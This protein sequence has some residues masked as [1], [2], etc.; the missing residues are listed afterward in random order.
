MLFVKPLAEYEIITLKSM[1]NNHPRHMSRLRAAVILASNKGCPV[2][3]I[4]Y[5][6]DVCRQSVAGW[7][8]LWENNGIASLFDKPRSGR[9][10]KLSE[11]I[12]EE[13][14]KLVKEEPRSIKKVL[15]KLRTLFGIKNISISTVKRIC[16]RAGLTWKRIR[17]SLKNKRNKDEFEKT[18]KML[19]ELIEKELKGDIDLYYFDE[20]GFNLEPYVPYA[21]QPVN[22][23]IEV[24]SSKSNRLNVLG[25]INKNCDFESFVFE[26]GVNSSI[27]IACFDAFSKIITKNTYILVDNASMHTSNEFKEQIEKWRKKGLFVVFNAPYS[28]E[29]NIIEILWR[30]IKYEWMPFSA[31]DSYENLKDELFKILR[32]IGYKNDYTIEFS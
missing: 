17:K 27:V 8:N 13:V 10:R 9:P 22:E 18:V 16:K 5:I 6:H 4:A 12:E 24:P 30:K 1:N 7:I 19:E 14:I 11:E 25:F 31:Y 23:H 26:G 2:Q 15:A 20:S 28:P 32:N 3:E 29:L 21:W